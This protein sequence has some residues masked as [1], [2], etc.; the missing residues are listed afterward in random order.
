LC[1]HSRIYP[2]TGLKKDINMNVQDILVFGDSK[3]IIKQ[4]RNTIHCV[5]NHLRNYRQLVQDLICKFSTFNITP[6]L[7]LQNAS[8]DLLE[9]VAS[10]LIP[11]EDFSPDRFSVELIFKPSI[12]D[13]I[14]NW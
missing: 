11:P 6:I 10:K 12:P 5:S 13:N 7:R 4:V 14:T 3:I 2:I 9:N 8:V 1:P